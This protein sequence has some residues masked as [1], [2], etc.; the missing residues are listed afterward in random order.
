MHRHHVLVLGLVASLVLPA[1]PAQAALPA[2][3]EFFVGVEGIDEDNAERLGKTEASLVAFESS[4][5]RRLLKGVSVFV[6][7]RC[8][9]GRF[10]TSEF[11]ARRV[12]VGRNGRFE[13]RL[14]A[15]REANAFLAS[16]VLQLGGRFGS[17]RR[18]RI[19]LQAQAIGNDGTTCHSGERR[20]LVLGE[21]YLGRPLDLAG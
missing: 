3:S 5:N 17:P 12:P 4:R 8:S 16:S 11:A 9:N 7:S 18:A 6:T 14:E 2:R 20:L 13:A 21:P 19:S 10:F 15:D 1:V